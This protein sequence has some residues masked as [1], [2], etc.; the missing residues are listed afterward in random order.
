MREKPHPSSRRRLER[1]KN[2]RDALDVVCD[3]KS[4][5]STVEEASCR[6]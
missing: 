2:K 1:D 4:G 5:A 6:H 3:F